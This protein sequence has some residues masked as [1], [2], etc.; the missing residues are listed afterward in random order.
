MQTTVKTVAVLVV[1][2]LFGVLTNS[3]HAAK[4]TND[5]GS[6]QNTKTVVVQPGDSLSKIA[7]KYNTTYQRLFN[8]NKKISHPDMIYPG[9]KIRIPTK[10]EQLKERSLPAIAIIPAPIQQA[11]T[12]YPTATEPLDAPQTVVA[13]DGEVWDKLA[14]CESGG[15][16][17]ID[18]GNGYQGGLQFHPGTWAAHGGSGSA[19]N[20]SRE[21]QI[22]VAKR[23]QSSQGWGA[24]PACAAKLGLR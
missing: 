2:I 18:T 21:E 1:T 12:G 5:K 9:D 13:G 3:T 24:W 23:V 4:P 6:R 19:A 22:A 15:N 7:D 20:A 14:Q 17:Q 8:A 11:V 16:W 10:S